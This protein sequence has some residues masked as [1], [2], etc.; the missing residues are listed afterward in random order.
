MPVASI[1][2][3][4]HV[5]I[6]ATLIMPLRYHRRRAVVGGG[7]GYW[8]RDRSRVRAL[9]AYN[10]RCKKTVSPR[11]LAYRRGDRVK[12]REFIMLLTGATRLS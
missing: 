8:T 10:A 7:R 4:V 9:L 11:L 5:S 3:I 6:P 1:F 2:V 12:R